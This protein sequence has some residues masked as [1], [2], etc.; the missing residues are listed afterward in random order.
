MEEKVIL[1]N[2]LCLLQAHSK[3]HKYDYGWTR[4]EDVL[5]I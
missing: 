5:A 2:M 1:T 4:T 3:I